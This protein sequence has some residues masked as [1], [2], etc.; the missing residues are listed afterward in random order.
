MKLP[1]FQNRLPFPHQLHPEDK[2]LEVWLDDG[3]G[4]HSVAKSDTYTK[5]RELVY[6]GKTDLDSIAKLERHVIGRDLR[7]ETAYVDHLGRICL[8]HDPVRATAAERLRALAR[9]IGGEA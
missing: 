5:V 2:N 1:A 4:W 3:G 6:D 9:V 8:D 7:K